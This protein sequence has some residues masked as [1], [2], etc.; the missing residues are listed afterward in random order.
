MGPKAGGMASPSGEAVCENCSESW[1]V[2]SLCASL[3]VPRTEG[4]ITTPHQLSLQLYHYTKMGVWDTG[5]AQSSV[6]GVSPWWR[7]W[8]EPVPTAQV[9]SRASTLLV[10]RPLD[11]VWQF[12]EGSGGVLSAPCPRHAQ[13]VEAA[14]F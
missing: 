11:S 14:L 1:L 12:R 5:V 10:G 3:M 9:P 6:N 4:Q 8:Q 7:R 2:G 13:R